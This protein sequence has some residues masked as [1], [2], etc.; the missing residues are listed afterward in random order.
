MTCIFNV[1]VIGTKWIQCILE[2]FLN[3]CSWRWLSPSRNLVKYWTPFRLWH[4]NMLFAV[5]LINFKILFLKILRLGAFWIS[6]SNL[7]HSMMTDGKKV[8]LKKLCL[9]LKWGILFAFLAVYGLFNLGIILE[10]YIGNWSFKFYKSSKVF[11]TNAC[12]E[13]SFSLDVPRIAPVMAAAVLYWML[14]PFY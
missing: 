9:T 12:V 3:L 10:R 2:V 13:K 4:P 5:G 11:C 14:H 8:F 1:A 7:F 6:G